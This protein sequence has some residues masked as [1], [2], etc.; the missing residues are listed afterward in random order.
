[1]VASLSHGNGLMT[2]ATHDLDERLTQ[3]QLLDGAALVQG[4][5]YTYTDGMNLTGIVDQLASS[6]TQSLQYS[7]ANR[8]AVSSGSWGSRS[9]GYDAVGNRTYESTTL[10]S[11]ASTLTNAATFAATSNR[12]TAMTQNAAAFR[13]YTYDGAGNILTDVRPG[14][15]FAYSYNNR[16]RL[17]SVTR[18]AAAW[19]TYV[20]NGLEQ[21]VS[22]VSQSPAAPI[23]TIHYIY[24]LDGHLIAEANGSTGA[25]TRVYIWLPANDNRNDTLAEDM[26]LAANDNAAPDLPL[27]VVDIA[28]TTQ[29][30]LQVH[31][32]HLGRPTRMTTAAKSTVWQASFKPWGEVQTITGTAIQNLRFPGQYFQVETGLAYNW[33][34]SYDPVTV[35]YTQPDPLRFVDGPSIYAYAGSSP[36]MKTDVT[37]LLASAESG[38]P[39]SPRPPSGDKQKTCTL[40]EKDCH[41]FCTD[42]CIGRGFGSDAPFCYWKCMKDCESY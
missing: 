30:L 32:D 5:G 9:Y 21:L 34:R 22:R 23:G 24:D 19:G 15:T 14:E 20:Y 28:G 18:N 36:Q 42:K 10:T 2:N 17:A 3:L 4:T 11:P 29:T 39:H 38:L 6:N 16:N 25:V 41:T 13:S 33:H 26:G 1:M 7:P 40:L 27:A 12:L 8:L 35:R 31:T 37:G